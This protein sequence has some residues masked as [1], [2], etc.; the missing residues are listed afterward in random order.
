MQLTDAGNTWNPALLVLK[1]KG[2]TLEWRLY[3]N[4]DGSDYSATRNGHT[5]IAETPVS[6]LGL[7]SIFEHFGENWQQGP[8]ILDDIP[9]FE[10]HFEEEDDSIEDAPINE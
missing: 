1:A 3:T 5:F 4:T 7:V 9:A 10:Y 8:L 2:Y 6:L